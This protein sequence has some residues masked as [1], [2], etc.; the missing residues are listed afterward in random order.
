MSGHPYR[1][2]PRPAPSMGDAECLMEIEVADVSSIHAWLA[3][4][5]LGIEVGA[6][7]IDLAAMFVHHVAELANAGF[8]HAVGRGVSHHQRR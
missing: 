2:H 8:K 7:E 5:N 3:Q 1:P 4:T 6:I